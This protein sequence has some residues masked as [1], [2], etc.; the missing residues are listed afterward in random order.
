MSDDFAAKFAE[1]EAAQKERQRLSGQEHELARFE[2]WYKEDGN[3]LC[4]WGAISYCA[5]KGSALPDWV[6]EYLSQAAA[7]LLDVAEKASPRFAGEESLKALGLSRPTGQTSPFEEFQRARKRQDACVLFARHVLDGTEYKIA[8]EDVTIRF[9]ISIATLNNWLRY[10]FPGRNSD[11]ETWLDFFRRKTN[12]YGP[13]FDPALSAVL[14][15]TA[16]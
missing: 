15:V 14:S 13:D 9:D 6:S 7:S 3:P 12:L 5:Q 16:I 11:D 4:A 8:Q 2:H 1:L 10:F